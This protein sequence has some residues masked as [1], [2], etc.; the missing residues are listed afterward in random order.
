MNERRQLGSGPRP[1][2]PLAPPTAARRAR[3]A[4]EA[5]P[6]P[7]PTEAAASE[8]PEQQSGRRTLGPGTTTDR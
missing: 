2:T 6:T 8:R 5:T 1:A 4:T 7:P 3:L